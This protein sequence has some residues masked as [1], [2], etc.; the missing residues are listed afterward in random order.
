MNQEEKISTFLFP[1]PFDDIRRGHRNQY[2]QK[3]PQAHETHYLPG[4]PLLDFSSEL[5]IGDL[6]SCSLFQGASGRNWRSFLQGGK[7]EGLLDI[8]RRTWPP[9][10]RHFVILH[11]FL[12]REP[13]RNTEGIESE[14]FAVVSLDP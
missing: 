13:A 8:W 4:V 6:A 10:I 9:F 5:K 12:E 1:L 11:S 3:D 2:Q 7:G 14:G